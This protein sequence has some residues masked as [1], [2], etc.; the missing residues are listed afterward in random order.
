M[1]VRMQ[2]V[3]ERAGVSLRTVS[4]VVNDYVHVSPET[5]E[6]VKRALDDL[7]YEV[8]WAARRLR[9]GRT[10]L[11]ALV[12]PNLQSPYFA[13]LA[14]AVV[15]AADRRGQALLVEVTQGDPER[16]LKILSG[17]R[18]QLRDG[19]LM[20]PYALTAA[21]DLPAFHRFPLVMLGESTLGSVFD[22]VGIDNVAAAQ[23]AVEHLF[24]QGRRRVAA[25]GLSDRPPAAAPRLQGYLAAHAARGLVP[26]PPVP[27]QDWTHASGARAVAEVLRLRDGASQRPDALFAFNDALALGALRA[28]LQ[29][30]VRV[31]DDVAG[32]GI[33]D[34]SE[35]AHATPPLTSVGTD[36]DA[37]AEQALLLLERQLADASS[38]ARSGRPPHHVRVPFTL[39]P[40]E[41]TR[42]EDRIAGR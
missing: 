19:T 38:G 15:K 28:L 29:A 37:L 8:N 13:M 6:K 31:P 22:H 4:N 9:S 23:M 7:G 5:R 12:V 40:R 17:G 24:D 41:S 18:N 32:V 33:D 35:A 14:D 27:V 42:G 30:G 1:S 2:D 36:L 10:G 25:V 26:L 34:L 3:A 20:S 11:V 39:T 21:M 16:E